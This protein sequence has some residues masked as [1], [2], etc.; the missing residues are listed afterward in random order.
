MGALAGMAPEDEFRNSKNDGDMP[1]LNTKVVETW[2]NETLKE[3]ES[4][5][6]PR[7]LLTDESKTPLSRFGVDRQRLLVRP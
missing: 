3:V 5:A 4:L 1:R 6:L 7:H 2:I